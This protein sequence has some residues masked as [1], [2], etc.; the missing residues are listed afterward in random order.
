MIHAIATV[1]LCGCLE[2]FMTVDEQKWLEPVWRI[3]S[4]HIVDSHC[5]DEIVDLAVHLWPSA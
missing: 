2:E 4:L 5:K 3:F 1:G